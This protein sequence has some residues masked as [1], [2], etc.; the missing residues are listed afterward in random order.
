MGPHHAAI[1]KKGFN[2]LKINRFFNFQPT[3]YRSQGRYGHRIPA[4][5]FAM[6]V[7][8]ALKNFQDACHTVT[9]AGSEP[10]RKNTRGVSP[11]YVDG[12]PSNAP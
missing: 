6:P 12:V 7:L 8:A 3:G 5:P 2:L 10:V 1:G 9:M 11:H 4:Y